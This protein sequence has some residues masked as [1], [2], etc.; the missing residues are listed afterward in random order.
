MRDEIYVGN[1]ISILEDDLAH[2]YK[3]TEWK[4]HKY[5]RKDSAGNYYYHNTRVHGSKSDPTRFHGGGYRLLDPPKLEGD[6]VWDAWH[7]LGLIENEDMKK[8]TADPEYQEY[9]NE[10]KRNHAEMY[11]RNSNTSYRERWEWRKSHP[12]SIGIY[13]QNGLDWFETHVLTKPKK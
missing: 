1:L 13:L 5:I 11:P 8:K 12:N 2:S 3:G 10:Y 4:K 7:Y 6:T 9:V